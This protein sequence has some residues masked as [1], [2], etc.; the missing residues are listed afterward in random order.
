M[1]I[2]TL[3]IQGYRSI[4]N[5]RLKMHDMNVIVGA[6]GSGKSNLYKAIHLI[7]KAAN[8]QLAETLAREGGMP[9]VLWAG[10]KKQMTSSKAPVRLT[11][12]VQLDELQYEIA[13]GLPTPSSSMF[14][15][16]PEVKA[17]YVWFGETKRPSSTL[18]ERKNNSTWMMSQDGVRIPYPASLSQSES[19]LSQLQEPHLHP[20]LFF[21][22]QEIKK[23]R[24][25]HHFRTDADS[26]IRGPQ[27]GTR[28]VVLS[29]DGYNLA[30]A[31][32]TIIEIGNDSLLHDAIDKAFPGARLVI[33]VDEKTRFD[34]QLKMPGILRPLEAR[35]LSDGTLRYLCLIAALLSPRPATLLALN[36]PEMSLHPELMQPLA[37]LI[38]MAS[39]S[40]QVWLTTHSQP[41]ALHIEKLSQQQPVNLIRTEEGTQID[42]LAL[43]ERQIIR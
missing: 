40:S 17:E 20:E 31:L 42:G 22:S 6:N 3:C 32:Q 27:I 26:P 23:W 19:V 25:Y 41:L 28:T 30:A 18:V 11:L 38:V 14:A 10:Q 13:C 36:E 35:E 21:L 34:I 9:S 43:W 37:E 5:M 24:F 29:E 33:H 2:K 1:A 16:D 12:S 7:A 8:G 4:Q 39:K 15:L